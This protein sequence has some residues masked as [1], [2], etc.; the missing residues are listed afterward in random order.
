LNDLAALGFEVDTAQLRK[1]AAALDGFRNS[2]KKL[3]DGNRGVETSLTRL[4]RSMKSVSG[5]VNLLRNAF[6]AYGAIRIGQ[7]ITQTAIAF[8][9]M[10]TTLKFA[11]GS[12]E[13]AKKEI[14][15]LRKESER[16]GQD[17]LIA[18]RAYSKLAAAGTALG[19]TTAEVRNT[20]TGVSSAAVVMGLSAYEA[21]G[22]FNALQQML[23]KGKVQAEE[24]RGQLGERIPTAIADGAAAMG[25]SIS[26][27]SKELELGNVNAKEFVTKLSD[28]WVKKF[29]ASIPNATENANIAITDFGNAIQ[30]VQ[31]AVARSGFL[32]GLT[33]GMEEVARILTNEDV[34]KG[35]RALG[36]A[37]GEGMKLAA[38]IIPVL[39]ENL[40]LLSVGI[41]AL[42]GAKLGSMFGPWWA[43]IG[44]AAGAAS[45]FAGALLLTTEEAETSEQAIA[46]L[47]A[48]VDN[49]AENLK[50]AKE[51]AETFGDAAVGVAF[52]VDMASE[53]LVTARN[54]LR[55]FQELARNREWADEFRS[56]M[57]AA[58]FGLGAPGG[59]KP[60]TIAE[61]FTVDSSVIDDAI[62]ELERLDKMNGE[63]AAGSKSTADSF[64]KMFD[65][66]D[67][68]TSL[69]DAYNK[70]NK[71][72]IKDNGLRAKTMADMLPLAQALNDER[73]RQIELEAGLDFVK[74]LQDQNKLL[75][76][77]LTLDE[78]AYE[79]LENQI[80]LRDTLGRDLLP[81]EL[82]QV[83]QLV[84]E[85]QRLNDK[86]E[87]QEKVRDLAK[88]AAE[89]Y[90]KTW[91]NAVEDVQ[92]ALTDGIEE[93][94][95]GN[96][97]SLDDWA[98]T[99][100]SIVRRLAANLLAQQLVIPFVGA[101][102]SALGIPGSP[103]GG[104]GGLGAFD[105]L[106]T[107][108]SLWSAFSGGTS[109]LA[110]SFAGSGLGAALGLSQTAAPALMA[111]AQSGLAIGG[112]GGVAAG[113]AG[114]GATL[115]GA[116]TALVGAAPYIAA[117]AAVAI[118]L[119]MATG[120]FQGPPSVGPTGVAITS[121][122]LNNGL[123][124]MITGT[125]NGG[126]AGAAVQ[127]L[128][129]ISAAAR[130][131]EDNL[132]G[133]VRRTD[134]SFG[135]D[136]SY[137]PEPED[138]TRPGG[139]GLNEIIDG[140]KRELDISGLSG[141]EVL[142]EGVVRTLKGAFET[143]GTSK[144]DMALQNTAATSLEELLAD[145][146]FAA[147]FDDLFSRAQIG[148]GPF[149]QVLDA[150]ADQFDAAK[151]KA[152]ELGFAT[153]ELTARY[154][155]AVADTMLGFE[156][157]LRAENLGVSGQ[158]GSLLNL[159]G[160]LEQLSTDAAAANVS[161]GLLAS[162]IDKRLTTSIKGLTNP[163][164][165]GLASVFEAMR[166][167]TAGAG[168]IADFLT[169][170]I[171]ST[172]ESNDAFQGRIL[173]TYLPEYERQYQATLQTIDALNANVAATKE[174][175][176]R[177]RNVA[178]S[179]LTDERLS[180]LSPMD[181]LA[182]ARAQFEAANIL[183]TDGTDDPETR[184]AI[185]SL[186]TLEQAM[187]EASLSY[188]GKSEGYLADF[189]RGQEVLLGISNHS[190][191]IDGQ[192]L[193]AIQEANTRLAN[194]A[195]IIRALGG[196]LPGD[197]LAD[198]GI[199]AEGGSSTVTADNF[200]AREQSYLQR[201]PDVFAAIKAGYFVSGYQHWLL[202]GQFEDGRPAFARGGSFE[203]TGRGG[204]DSLTMPPV[205]V[206][207]GEVANISRADTMAD[208]SKGILT[209]HDDLVGVRDDL[210]GS[211][212]ANAQGQQALLNENK[213]Q[214]NEIKD[215]NQRLRVLEAKQP[216]K[217][218][219]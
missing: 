114:S 119:I 4:E 179:R 216:K 11:T 78:D 79:I 166:D 196:A 3:A 162:V 172:S 108:S 201:N 62:Q 18:G 195:S 54:N 17:F 24:L 158:F 38:E 209:V 197:A 167:A 6:I 148:I 204:I 34:L 88:E 13:G 80:D 152:I 180:P 115:T 176:L 5:T 97:R 147:G 129:G 33:K 214:S 109:S 53:A 42:T 20:F 57:D 73:A 45:G 74:S 110:S 39:A 25:M 89:A 23:A 198:P 27:M 61:A 65:V 122:I 160:T 98:D 100:M 203:I 85:Q 46:R 123:P 116:G 106:N 161:T 134:R 163:E 96:L 7:S 41:G 210:R 149:E 131:I 71:D 174:L 130:S 103:G 58:N 90:A 171:S 32:E 36:R 189:N 188:H 143:L 93:A 63:L 145:L 140:V 49:A 150:L 94:L 105:L 183:A 8:Q 125:D 136:V 191:S 126:N 10:E 52:Q 154:D 47:Q 66:E 218:A 217:R 15:F 9:K 40:D 91:E 159:A 208:L 44:A 28:Y 102:A 164:L 135:L 137:Y 151:E 70:A 193:S 170:A 81:E 186:P 146:D 139:F 219:A 141:E 132:D 101:G 207:A 142:F 156:Q 118:P 194:I 133:S 64:Q 51:D 82:A 26:Q 48:E 43:A 165:Q 181:R 16:L 111:G 124:D 127:A 178:N 177:F 83:K 21:E 69:A 128:M 199:G 75:E 104:G 99:F 30:E 107:G 22:A 212:E 86:I 56:A 113:A 76:A 187:L 173:N 215:L 169:A 205:R 182:E 95:S 37:L 211:M 87:E 14:A 29:G 84:S 72:A 1:G 120:A 202:D 168:R 121:R 206:T 117:A 144:L 155:Q 192:Q 31:L 175:G 67:E 12:A 112:Y 35:A 77:K 153:E 55:E 213:R 185:Q 184:N 60:E 2:G 190:L 68:A 50:L 200:A 19:L 59:G 92:G 157:S 138:G